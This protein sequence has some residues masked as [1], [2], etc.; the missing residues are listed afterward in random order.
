MHDKPEF[1]PVRFV[2]KGM[3]SIA[4]LMIYL[5]SCNSSDK[6]NPLGPAGSPSPAS[7]RITLSPSV[8][9]VDRSGTIKF[10]AIGGTGAYTWTVSDRTLALIGASDGAFTAGTTEGTVVVT[11]TDSLGARGN[12]NISI[13]SKAVTVSPAS[14]QVPT[15]GSQT[16]TSNGTAPLFWT[17]SN[18]AIGAIGTTTGVFTA[19]STAGSATVSVLD[20]AGGTGSA[21]VT[22]ISTTMILTPSS[23][24]FAQLPSGTVTY[25][26]TGAVGTV[27]YSLSGF[28]NGYAGTTIDSG[29]GEVTISALPTTAQG[30]QTLTITASDGIR[31]ATA[32]LTLNAS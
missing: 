9:S 5:V 7:A 21:T 16:F 11:A 22:V 15:G 17:V 32:T 19:T 24:A 6:G 26:A 28:A 25:V 14:A 2:V 18:T 3:L 20:S 10:S 27:Y 12:A 23:L 13:G 8:A 1:K 30:N 4:A 31:S 29:T